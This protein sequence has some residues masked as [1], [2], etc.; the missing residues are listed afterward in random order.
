MSEF[1][2]DL[3]R[4]T[5][6]EHGVAVRLTQ[7]A[8][9]LVALLIL[10]RLQERAGTQSGWVELDDISLLQSWRGARSLV[11][12]RRQVRREIEKLETS[13]VSAV[14][15]RT[16]MKGPFRLALYPTAHLSDISALE[17]IASTGRVTRVQTIEDV[18]RFADS[19]EPLWRGMYFFDRKGTDLAVSLDAFKTACENGVPLVQAL[20]MIQAGR[21][22]RELARFEEAIKQLG[23]AA[24]FAEREVPNE[25]RS[26][27]RASVLLEMAWVEYRRLR[28]DKAEMLISEAM[29]FAFQAG[30]AR[31]LGDVLNLR[32]LLYRRQKRFAEALRCHCTALEYWIVSGHHYGIQSFYHNLAC[33]C[34]E[35]A[36]S[37]SEVEKE[38]LLE[39]AI[40]CA[41]RCVQMCNMYGIGQNTKLSE[42]LLAGLY[43]KRGAFDDAMKFADLAWNGAS[44]TGSRYEM[45]MA[46]YNI[47]KLHLWRKNFKVA[48]AFLESY[49]GDGGN[50]PFVKLMKRAYAI[51]RKQ[52]Q[53]GS[54]VVPTASEL[55]L[56]LR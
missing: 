14:H 9:G 35:Y 21:T 17:R 29:E 31:V 18:L 36:E 22:M 8:F 46:A 32:S 45:A 25:V 34:A 19:A 50:A 49:C 13:G 43:A 56:Q 54:A 40:R 55:L 1:W 26:L 37:S 3:E 10:R 41:K 27:F 47:L 39:A 53:G 42:I 30:Q 7:K 2:L 11:S 5:L 51:M 12:L 24:E 33:W 44:S 15:Y 48:E 38:Q 20:A 52:V 23:E 4:R 6:H 16:K 28:F